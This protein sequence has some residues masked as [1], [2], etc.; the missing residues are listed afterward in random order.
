MTS[1]HGNGFCI[2]GPLWGESPVIWAMALMDALVMIFKQ[3]PIARGRHWWCHPGTFIP[4]KYHYNDV[5]MSAVASQITSLTIVYPTVYSGADQRENQIS[6]L[7]ALC[8]GNSPVTG[9]FPTQRASN[10]ENAS[11]WRRHHDSWSHYA[12]N[13]RRDN[14]VVITSKLRRFDVITTPLLRHVSAG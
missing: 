14:N 13:T 7:L 6:A 1:W 11:I 9:E 5:I 4:V 3:F 10:A 2:T 12:L 8:A